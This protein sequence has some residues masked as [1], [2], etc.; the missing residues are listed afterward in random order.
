MTTNSRENYYKNL[1]PNISKSN[2]DKINEILKNSCHANSLCPD[3]FY[4]F[5][6][7]YIKWLININGFS[8][9]GFSVQIKFLN[10]LPKNVNGQMNFPL[11][12]NDKNLK[13]KLNKKL[14]NIDYNQKGYTSKLRR[15]FDSFAHECEHVIQRIESYNAVLENGRLRKQIYDLKKQGLPKKILNQK[16]MCSQF[17]SETEIGA[18]RNSLISLNYL[19]DLLISKKENES[20]KSYLSFL[21]FFKKLLEI[22]KC[23]LEKDLTELHKIDNRINKHIKKRFDVEFTK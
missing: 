18:R 17:I 1:N 21:K 15:A 3:E 16:Y 7:Y 8:D 6:Q 10:H 19:F 4:N 20:D 23:Y 5:A 2:L 14:Y 13:I 12:E 22:R 9:K 11:C